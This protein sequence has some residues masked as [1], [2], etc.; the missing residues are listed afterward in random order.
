MEVNKITPASVGH[1]SH[2]IHLK[3]FTKSGEYPLTTTVKTSNSLG[4]GISFTICIHNIKH[5]ITSRMDL[6]L[7]P[8]ETKTK[9]DI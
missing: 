1:R 6:Q 5:K 4:H 7:Q 9:R 3:L 2:S 8:S